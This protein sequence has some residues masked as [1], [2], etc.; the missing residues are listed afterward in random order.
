MFLMASGYAGAFSPTSNIS[1]YLND[2]FYRLRIDTRLVRVQ[3]PL[4]PSRL[5]ACFR[6]SNAIPRPPAKRAAAIGIVNGCES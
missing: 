2:G 3:Q 1:D 4:R 6:V 5:I